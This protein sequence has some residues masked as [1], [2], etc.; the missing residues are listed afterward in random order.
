MPW[1]KEP[2]G[3]SQPLAAPVLLQG[4]ASAVPDIRQSFF[5]IRQVFWRKVFRLTKLKE[6][7]HYLAKKSAM[8]TLNDDLHLFNYLVNG[9][10]FFHNLRLFSPRLVHF[11]SLSM[12]GCSLPYCTLVIPE[13]RKQE[14]ENYPLK[15]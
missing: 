7:V 10:I 12:P 3:I 1:Q 8:R 9:N 11:D 14:T 6:T 15:A 4:K 13:N 2:Y 5:N